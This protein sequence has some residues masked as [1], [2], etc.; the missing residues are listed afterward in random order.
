ME[1]EKHMQNISLSI[2]LERE[3]YLFFK[4]NLLHLLD[5]VFLKAFS[6]NVPLLVSLSFV[7]NSLWPHGL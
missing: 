7:S 2:N 6:N 5:Q 1:M 3:Q 4:K